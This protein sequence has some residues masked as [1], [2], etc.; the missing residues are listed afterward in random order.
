MQ[1]DTLSLTRL[2]RSTERD[3][4]RNSLAA[5]AEWIAPHE[6]PQ[7]HHRVIMAALERIERTRNDRLL[8]DPVTGQQEKPLRRLMIFAPPG[9]AKSV[10]ATVKFTSWY[11]GRNPRDDVICASHTADLAERFGRKVRNIVASTE[12]SEVF[13]TTISNDNAAAGRWAMREG[14]EYNSVGVGGSITGRRCMGMLMD[15]LVPSREAADSETYRA[16]CWEWWKADMRTRMKPG[17]WAVLIMTRWHIEDIAGLLLEDMKSGGEQWEVLSLPMEA[18]DNDPL[19]RKPGELLWPEWFT[20]EMVRIA[21]R[22]ERG[23]SALYQQ[24]PTPDSGNYFKREWIKW[25]DKAPELLT[26]YGASDY[27]VTEKG[28][29]TVHA[30]FGVDR[31]DDLYLLEMWR[32]KTTTDKWIEVWMDM[33][34]MWKPVEWLEEKGQIEKGVGPFIEKAM[35]ERRKYVYRRAFAS[36]HD[37]PTRAQSIRGRFAQ[38]KVYLPSGKPWVSD[39]ITELMQFPLGKHDDFCD[40]I[41]LMGRALD[42]LRVPHAK[43]G[44]SPSTFRAYNQGMTIGDFMRLA[45]KPTTRKNT[46]L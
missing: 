45:N 29:Y 37:K 34:T 6:P 32:E 21:K 42:S 22:D 16:K 30:I 11:L 36:S 13:G 39:C 31:D 5:Y 46:G 28:D 41:S 25:Y 9:S 18:E 33:V 8:T 24:R 14:A 4:A 7:R 17:A 38:G 26:I 35:K 43:K 3:A 15:D 20:P 12:F 27:A 40:T 44:P 23:W 1:D 2:L 10:T 19:G